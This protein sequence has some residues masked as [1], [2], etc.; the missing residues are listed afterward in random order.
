MTEDCEDDWRMA[1]SFL[2]ASGRPRPRKCQ[3]GFV[4]CKQCETVH[5]P[6]LKGGGPISCLKPSVSLSFTLFYCVC[7]CVCV[8]AWT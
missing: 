6:R 5:C 4:F 2:I 8:C 3:R 1:S 7:V